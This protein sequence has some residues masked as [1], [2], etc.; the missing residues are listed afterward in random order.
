MDQD[1]CP[2]VNPAHCIRRMGIPHLNSFV[3]STF[4]LLYG[5]CHGLPPWMLPISCKLWPF[6]IPLY[7][8]TFL[9]HAET[10][11]WSLSHDMGGCRMGP[12]YIEGGSRSSHPSIM[13]SNR[14]EN[15]SNNA[16]LHSDTCNEWC[17]LLQ[18]TPCALQRFSL[19]HV[20]EQWCQQSIHS[21]YWS[22]NT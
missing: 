21:I 19:M 13:W 1:Y 15:R 22:N 12:W 18:P 20:W 2:A 17:G 8:C 7:P 10:C 5:P 16:S 6:S 3:C 14:P 9:V 4:C 11:T